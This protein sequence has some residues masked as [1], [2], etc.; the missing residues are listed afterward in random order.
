MNIE[1]NDYCVKD[2]IETA[3]L[4]A[5]GKGSRLYPLTENS[6]KCLTLVN[7]QPILG[8]LVSGLKRKGFKKLIIVTGYLQDC[9][10][11]F[12]GTQ[13]GDMIIEYVYSPLYETTNNIYSLWMARNVIK[14]P[15]VLFESDIIFDEF[16]LD[17]IIYPDR[18]AVAP[19][20]NFMNG[21]TVTLN[22]KGEID[23][24][25]NEIPSGSKKDHY[26]TV[27]IYSFSLPTWDKIK[28]K[29]NDYIAN[30]KVNC[31]YELVFSELLEQGDLSLQAVFFDNRSWYEIDTIGDLSNAEKLCFTHNRSMLSS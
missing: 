7:N 25:Y 6:P 1:L 29:L 24:F 3:L 27:N 26:K 2:K 18:I 30:K 19:M 20:T 14:E 4:L 23:K 11:D 5:A 12:L 9:I 13:S 22:K 17:D 21:T 15:F 8:K 10:K 16:L 28:A 31:Y